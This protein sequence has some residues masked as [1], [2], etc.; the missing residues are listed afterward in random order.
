MR[1]LE[2]SFHPDD[3]EA[4]FGGADIH[5]Q[6]RTALLLGTV[7]EF[8]LRGLTDTAFH[9]AF[10][11][12]INITE[13]GEAAGLA[14]LELAAIALSIHH[15]TSRHIS[16]T[17]RFLIQELGAAL[18]DPTLT[19]HLPLQCVARSLVASDLLRTGNARKLDEAITHIIIAH[20]CTN[21]AGDPEL[22]GIGVVSEVFS[23]AADSV[24]EAKMLATIEKARAEYA[25]GMG[26]CAAARV[27]RVL[28][29]CAFVGDLDPNA[30]ERAIRARDS[31][32]LLGMFFDHQTGDWESILSVPAER[33]KTVREPSVRRACHLL[34]ASAAL[35]SSDQPRLAP[36]TIEQM[37]S[38]TAFILEAP[39][40][41]LVLGV[42]AYQTLAMNYLRRGQFKA[43][44]LVL[45]PVIE[46]LEWEELQ[47]RYENH[48]NEMLGVSLYARAQTNFFRRCFLAMHDDLEAGLMLLPERHVLRAR[49]E[50]A[51]AFLLH[52]AA[53]RQY[54]F[55]VTQNSEGA[56]DAFIK[57]YEEARTRIPF[58]DSGEPLGKIKSW[59]EYAAEAERVYRE[60]RRHAS[61][62]TLKERAAEGIDNLHHFHPPASKSPF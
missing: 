59:S 18:D 54:W 8:C 20:R 32:R 1:P 30:N 62:P 60:A 7:R 33:Y 24:I 17:N 22:A 15:D 56:P 45:T 34:R 44:S 38:F 41:V 12:L 9:E 29:Q 26:T 42:T 61:N 49:M 11:G 5:S 2:E 13:K 6:C 52:C 57:E 46:A 14:R 25:D 21:F 16:D 43:S 55:G 27:K 31:L 23:K 28:Q 50:F 10:D 48:T 53:L 40:G 19:N 4:P 35:Q 3:H 47:D 36:P 39:P 37:R 58:L 51:E